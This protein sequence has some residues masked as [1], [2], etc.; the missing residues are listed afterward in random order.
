LTFVAIALLYFGLL[1]PFSTA[2]ESR[3]DQARTEERL[4]ELRR[5]IESDEERLSA[6]REKEEA[7]L[8]TLRDLDRQIAMR[9]ELTKNYRTRMDELRI[10]QDTLVTSLNSLDEELG[11]LK[12]EYQGRAVHGYKYGRMHDLALI[13]AAQSINQMLVRVSYLKRFANQRRSRLNELRTAATEIQNQRHELAMSYDRNEQLLV[14]AEAEHQKLAKLKRDRRRIVSKLKSERESLEEELT[15]R[16]SDAQLLEARIRQI[17]AAQAERRR[18][19]TVSTETDMVSAQLTGSFLQNKGN[20][21]WPSTGVVRI[22]FGDIVNPVH[23]TKTPNP[24]LVIDTE[25]S[26]AV[27]SVFE[28][29]VISVDIIP[30]FGT[31]VVIEHGDYHS[32][33]SNFSMLYVGKN[34]AVTAGQ[35]IGRSGTEAEP[36]G[37]G[38]FFAL[39][40]EGK[41]FDPRPW[42]SK[43]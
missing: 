40:K 26:A 39:F 32:V 16:K 13:L 15:A 18:S 43:L 41:P 23:G 8:K 34:E 14:A 5:L 42:L 21:P 10:Q 28:G 12:R 22:P 3:P 37:A 36:K 35:I 31:Y 4:Q 24:G 2:Q 9:S 20:L 7:N 29:R 11:T 25:P 30:D 6:A 38:V 17:V 27:K 19:R 1:V 33:Y